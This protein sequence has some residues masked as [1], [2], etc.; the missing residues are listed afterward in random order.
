VID[1][2]SNFFHRRLEKGNSDP[3]WAG[4]CVDARQTIAAPIHAVEALL[5]TLSFD[6][7]MAAFLPETS[8]NLGTLTEFGTQMTSSQQGAS[9]ICKLTQ[10]QTRLERSDGR[11]TL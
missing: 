7:L 2:R 9:V 6:L 5:R 10:A 1:A 8:I 4:T 3:C 11:I